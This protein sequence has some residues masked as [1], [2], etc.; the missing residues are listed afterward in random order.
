MQVVRHPGEQFSPEVW[1]FA[2]SLS[3]AGYSSRQVEAAIKQHLPDERA[4][5]YRQIARWRGSHEMTL[6]ESEAALQT[7]REILLRAQRLA[8]DDLETRPERYNAVQLMTVAGIAHDKL[9]KAQDLSRPPPDH[10]QLVIIVPG[11]NPIQIT[12]PE[13]I[14]IASDQ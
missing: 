7:H 12:D 13:T 9:F 10:R 2:R 5:S 6:E 4:P 11:I 3:L 8:L 1:E 14:D